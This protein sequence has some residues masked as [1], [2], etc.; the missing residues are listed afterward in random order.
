MPEAAVEATGFTIVPEPTALGLQTIS[1]IA[2]IRPR[3]RRRT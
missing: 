3:R 2:A 1:T